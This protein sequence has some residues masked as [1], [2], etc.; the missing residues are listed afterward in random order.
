MHLR[1]HPHLPPPRPRSPAPGRGFPHTPPISAH[2]PLMPHDTLR[3]GGPNRSW[4]RRGE[5]SDPPHPSSS[6]ISQRP[7]GPHLK[8]AASPVP[9]PLGGAS[10]L[11]LAAARAP[12]GF[13]CGEGARGTGA[14]VCA[15]LGPLGLLSWGPGCGAL[16]RGAGCGGSGCAWPRAGREG[17]HPEPWAGAGCPGGGR[18]KSPLS[19]REPANP[20]PAALGPPGP[21]RR[22]RPSR[23]R[24]AAAGDAGCPSSPRA[25]RRPAG[26]SGER[27]GPRAPAQAAGPRAEAK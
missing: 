26:G 16:A 19:R 9:R 25:F 23:W 27:R 15:P 1:A 8:P 2:T 12:G 4:T 7:D 20:P 21:R 24:R 18:G 22:P 5:V 17:R 10:V 11:T 3:G 6:S 13:T 14:K